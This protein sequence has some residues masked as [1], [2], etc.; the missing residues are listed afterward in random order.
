MGETRKTKVI[1][2]VFM[3]QLNRHNILSDALKCFVATAYVVRVTAKH[4][5]VITHQL[6][7]A[8]SHLTTMCLWACRKDI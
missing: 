5:A 3:R 8:K 4:S 6:V 7:G 2:T 1:E